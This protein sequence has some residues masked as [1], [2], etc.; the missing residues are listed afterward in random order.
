[1]RTPYS[2]PIF[3]IFFL[4]FFSSV[5]DCATETTQTGVASPQNAVEADNIE[6]LRQRAL[7]NALDL[8]LLQVTGAMVSGERSDSL[9]T[10]EETTIVGDRADAATRLQ[11]RHNTTGSTQTRG[12]ARLVEIVKEWQEKGQYYV[13]AR[14][15]ID[16]EEEAAAK[17]D[18]GHYWLQAGKPPIALTLMEELNGDRRKV[19]DD[20]T[21]R[22]FRDTLV[23]NGVELSENAPPHYTI[24]LLQVVNTQELTAF[25]TTT[26]NCQVSY[27]LVDSSRGVT[28][29]EHKESHGPDAGF[30]FDQ[31]KEKCIGGAV[32]AVSENL[33]R[34]LAK[35]WN[36]NWN[37]GIEQMITIEHLPGDLVPRVNTI[38]QNLHRISASTP[39]TF[40]NAKFIKKV[41]F[42][43]E[44][45]EL[46]AAILAAF[47]DENWHVTVTAIQGNGISLLW[48]DI[49]QQ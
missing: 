17:H 22:F 1:M 45:S 42:K 6:L 46:A 49:P 38:V 27:R 44:G 19:N 13:T 18:L 29:A 25:D 43:G 37:N 24:E 8:A 32:P 4:L 9:R 36:Q 21:V 12:H 11:S 48:Q 33:I 31:A 20:R 30:S 35:V 28:I 26:A 47:E 14:I 39:A 3:V 41:T 34:K 10:R 15:A 2:L 5:G 16:S 40:T 23:R 7:R